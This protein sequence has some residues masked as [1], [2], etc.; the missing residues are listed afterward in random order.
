[1][2]KSLLVCDCL[3]SQSVDR[4]AIEAGTGIGCSRL[5]TALCTRE[6]AKAAEALVEGD[7]AIACGQEIARFEELADELGVE[8]PLLVDIRDRAGWSDESAEAG[9][10][11]AALV[12]DA[13]LDPPAQIAG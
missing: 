4:N 1:M 11:Q 8:P 2:P 13:A 7:V 5:H 10:K 9:P 3:G 12:A 6:I